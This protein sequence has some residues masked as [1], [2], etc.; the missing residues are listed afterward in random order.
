[1]CGEKAPR[2]VVRERP[3]R[4]ESRHVA[5]VRSYSLITWRARGVPVGLLQLYLIFSACF[6]IAHVAL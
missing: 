5:E 2:L 4:V 6:N 3:A 1:M